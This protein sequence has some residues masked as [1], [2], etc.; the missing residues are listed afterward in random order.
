MNLGLVQP[1]VFSLS[2]SAYVQI[3]IHH[4]GPQAAA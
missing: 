3:L 2:H 4:M 1:V